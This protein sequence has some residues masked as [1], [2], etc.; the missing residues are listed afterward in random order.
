[1]PDDNL[2]VEIN[3]PEKQIW[4]GQAK[5]VSSINSKGPFDILPLHSNFITIIENQPIK[6]NTGIKT[7]EFKFSNSVLFVSKNKVIIYTL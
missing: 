3:S 2:I 5:S 4:N 6:I 1:M 7:E